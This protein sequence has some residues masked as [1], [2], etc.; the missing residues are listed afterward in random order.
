MPFEVVVTYPMRAG[1]LDTPKGFLK[2]KDGK[3]AGSVEHTEFGIIFSFANEEESIWC[4][5]D[6]KYMKC[7]YVVLQYWEGC[8]PDGENANVAGSNATKD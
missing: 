1:D 8:D 3:I 2:T 4:D 6:Q 5:T 7:G